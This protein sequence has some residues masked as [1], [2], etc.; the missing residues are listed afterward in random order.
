MQK[1]KEYLP[2]I[3]KEIET[4]QSGFQDEL[5]V[6]E[7][8]EPI[9]YILSIGGK[10]LRPALVL[11]GANLFQDDISQAIRP[12]VGVEVFHNFTLLHDDIMDEA[13]L[14]R[15]KETVHTKWNQNIAILSGDA[16]MIKAYDYFADLPSDLFK[17]VFHVFSRTAMEVCIGQQ[18][19]MN[20][21]TRDDVTIDEYIEMIKLKTSVLIAGAL[22]IGGIIGGAS[23]NEVEAL[24]DYGVNLGLSFQMQDDI[25]DVYADQE[26][27]GK[28]IGGDIVANKK[29]FLLIKAQ[30]L[31]N[32]ALAHELDYWLQQPQFDKVEKIEAVKKIY[33]ELGVRE[34]T[35]QMREEYYRKALKAL[36]RIQD[37]KGRLHL[38]YEFAEWLMKRNK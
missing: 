34:I 36:E 14:R 18:Y 23:E 11:M 7:L 17:S 1:L 33:Q 2:L 24:Y 8:Y 10:R 25:L 12:A 38:L 19:D 28:M 26:V 15:G 31:A 6:R 30:E 16:M 5:A 35:E 13:P 32:G 20:F 3:E 29:T 37:K 21:E 9:Q 27:F 22:K 4:S